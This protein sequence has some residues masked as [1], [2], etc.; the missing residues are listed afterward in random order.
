MLMRRAIAATDRHRAERRR[1][2]DD[3]LKDM[4]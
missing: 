3:D 1:D 4:R 2:L